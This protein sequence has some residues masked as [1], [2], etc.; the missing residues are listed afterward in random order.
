MRWKNLSQNSMVLSC[1]VDVQHVLFEPLAN[2]PL[3]REL[4][5]LV[6]IYAYIYQ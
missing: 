6:E 2:G 3:T 4:L 5:L 1:R